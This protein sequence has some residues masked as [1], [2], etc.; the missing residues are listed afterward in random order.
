MINELMIARSEQKLMEAELAQMF[1]RDG[2]PLAEP[3]GAGVVAALRWLPV[4]LAVVVGL[5]MLTSG[6]V[7]A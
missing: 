2:V 6:M 4:V 7:A 5:T 1:T 3:R